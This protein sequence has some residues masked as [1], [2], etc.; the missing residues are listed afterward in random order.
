MND[1]WAS[2]ARREQ[3]KAHPVAREV[4]EAMM[5]QLLIVLVNRLG[6]EVTVPVIEL[7]AT[8]DRNLSLRFDEPT[9]SFTFVSEF[10][11]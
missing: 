5:G 7:D 1:N 11:E 8:G 3:S 2:R 10:K 4:L 9:R 6:G